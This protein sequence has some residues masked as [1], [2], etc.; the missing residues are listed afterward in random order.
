M[1]ARGNH[2]TPWVDGKWEAR[3][4]CAGHGDLY[5]AAAE[6]EPGGGQRGTRAEL[7]AIINA[8]KAICATCPVKDPCLDAAHTR[9]EPCGIWGGLTT[10]ERVHQR[11]ALKLADRIRNGEATTAQIIDLQRR[12]PNRA[13]QT[14]HREAG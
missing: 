8:A 4:A 3:A 6:A 11:R 7:A 14:R 1:S 9:H 5:A 12:A 10:V 13:T 2:H